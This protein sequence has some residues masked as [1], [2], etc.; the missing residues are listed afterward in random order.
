MSDTENFNRDFKAKP[1]NKKIIVGPPV[2]VPQKEKRQLTVPVSPTLHKSKPREIVK[3]ESTAHFKA[4]PIPPLAPF[5]PVIQ[6]RYVAPSDF[7]LPGDDISEKKKQ[8]IEQTIQEQL[9]HEEKTR[10]FKAMPIPDYSTVP[11]RKV[12]PKH[13]TE[14]QPFDFNTAKRALM[15][16]KSAEDA[17]NFNFVARPAPQHPPFEPKKSEKPPTEPE[18]IVLQSAVRAEERRAFDEARQRKEYMIEEMKRQAQ[19]QLQK[20]EEEEIKRIRS[21]QVHKAQP[22]REYKPVVIQSS[23]RKLTRPASPMFAEKRNE[24]MMN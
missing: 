11:T 10:N 23:S 2:G 8:R 5:V 17:F 16:K 22:I 19:E 4:N 1:L 9:A 3:E 12:E 18:N 15:T 20:R 13:V 21:L 14:P 6:H 24:P 7:H